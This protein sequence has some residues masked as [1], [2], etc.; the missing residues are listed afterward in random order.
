MKLWSRAISCSSMMLR[1]F[2][3]LQQAMLVS[4]DG[5]LFDAD[6]GRDIFQSLAFQYLAQ[7]L[8]LAP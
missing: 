4:G 5:A 3:F 1:A 6:I 2:T 8:L 7:Y